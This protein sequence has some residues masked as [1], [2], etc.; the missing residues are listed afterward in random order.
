MRS[1]LGYRKEETELRKADGSG[2]LSIRFP[3]KITLNLPRDG[4]KLQASPT[5]NL[6]LSCKS[7]YFS[8]SLSSA[9]FTNAFEKSK[10]T[11]S[12]KYLPNSIVLLPKAHPR[13]STLPFKPC[14]FASAITAS[15][16]ANGKFL[17]PKYYS[18]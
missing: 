7:A 4:C 10:P 15:A 13:S 12:S 11:A 5:T 1:P 14:P 9:F 6:T 16:H 8:C 3:P 2:S 17:I 18:P